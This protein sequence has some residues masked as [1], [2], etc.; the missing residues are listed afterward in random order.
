[1]LG[2]RYADEALNPGNTLSMRE[3]CSLIPLTSCKLM[4]SIKFR[5][6]LPISNGGAQPFQEVRRGSSRMHLPRAA[7]T[8]AAIGNSQRK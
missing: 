7:Q 4:T 1:M 3:Q 5:S 2:R 8:L 6:E